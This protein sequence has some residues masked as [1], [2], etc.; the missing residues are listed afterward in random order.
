VGGLPFFFAR[1]C[2]SVWFFTAVSQEFCKFVS[3]CSLLLQV[4][5]IGLLLNPEEILGL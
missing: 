1:S 2:Y 3:T 5:M 4:G